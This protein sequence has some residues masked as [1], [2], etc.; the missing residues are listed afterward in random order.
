[1]IMTQ[2]KIIQYVI[3]YKPEV[4]HFDEV[5][6]EVL[7]DDVSI[8]INYLGMERDFYVFM[9]EWFP[10]EW[11]DDEEEDSYEPFTT[12]HLMNFFFSFDE[13]NICVE[14]E[15]KKYYEV[16]Q[17]CSKPLSECCGGCSRTV[18]CNC[19]ESDKLFPL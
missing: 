13:V 16:L 17:E 4:Y 8:R 9:K 6:F 14:C 15:G 3:G 19:L 7:P 10:V 18:Q 11:K 2:E 5:V 12:K 1:M